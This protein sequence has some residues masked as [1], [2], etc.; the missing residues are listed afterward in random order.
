M[1]LQSLSSTLL[2][3]WPSTCEKLERWLVRLGAT[4]I[5]RVEAGVAQGEAWVLV[6]LVQ[7][8]EQL[9]EKPDEL[10]HAI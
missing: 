9:S 2:L 3:S 1:E 5:N 4:L 8:S 7:S 10:Q 6:L